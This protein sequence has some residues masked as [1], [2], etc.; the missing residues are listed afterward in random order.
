[1]NV[2]KEELARVQASSRNEIDSIRAEK[3]SVEQRIADLE[4]QLTSAQA[5]HKSLLVELQVQHDNDLINVK[6]S[7][8]ASHKQE[9]KTVQDQ[10]REEKLARMEIELASNE[11]VEAKEKAEE[12]AAAAELKLKQMTDMINE[13]ENLKCANEKLHTSLQAETE[14]RKILHNTIEDMKGELFPL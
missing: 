12:R 8:M 4:D 13:T 1:V 10:L 9:I 5:S 2:I 11:A 14:K 6:S 7:M 3:E